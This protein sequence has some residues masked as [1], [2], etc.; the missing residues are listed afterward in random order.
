MLS[1]LLERRIDGLL[2]LFG[3]AQSRH[4]L[5]GSY[6]KGMRQKVLISAAL[7]HD[8]E[9]L[10][11]DEPLSGLDITTALVFR[12]LVGRLAGR[13]KVVLFSSHVLDA[14]EKA[15]TSV[16]ILSGG[17]IIAHDTVSRLKELRSRPP[18]SA[19]SPTSPWRRILDASRARSS[20][21]CRP[22]SL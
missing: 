10:V 2:E 6:S 1:P 18:S 16:V 3:L 4:G 9:L 15:C 7:L 8:P 13:G 17:R 22:G 19:S 5:L 14:I 11:F 12:S 21:S 20:T